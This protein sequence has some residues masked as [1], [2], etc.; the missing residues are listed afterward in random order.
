ML[1]PSKLRLMSNGAL[2]DFPLKYL[3]LLYLYF[4]YYIILLL[5]SY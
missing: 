1:Q 4:Y 2:V 3:G 5:I